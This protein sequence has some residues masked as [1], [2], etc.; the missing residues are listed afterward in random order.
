MASMNRG[1]ALRR[2]RVPGT[3]SA[4]RRGPL[5]PAGARP[6]REVPPLAADPARCS[7]SS[8]QP[9]PRRARTSRPSWRRARRARG[10]TDARRGSAARR[11][12]RGS[13]CARAPLRRRSS[14]ATPARGACAA[15]C[16]RPR[17]PRSPRPTR[18]GSRRSRT[19]RRARR[20]GSR[21]RPGRGRRAGRRRDRRPARWTWPAPRAARGTGGPCRAL[22]AA[23]RRREASR[24]PS[25]RSA[26]TAGA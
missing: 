13:A 21:P 11:A 24:A 22:R 12:P 1:A 17:R 16:A 2:P 3:T 23:P 18:C 5:G 14:C 6:S 8:A 4:R 26:R 9:R 10:G 15:R 7:A 20:A 25:D 19:G